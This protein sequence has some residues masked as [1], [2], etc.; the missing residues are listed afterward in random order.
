MNQE[1]TFNHFK[2]VQHQYIRIWT[3]VC[4]GSG[5]SHS[6]LSVK[7]PYTKPSFSGLEL[8]M[9]RAL[10]I[11]FDVHWMQNTDYNANN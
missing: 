8:E 3:W 6:V 11:L 10:G 5:G 9:V 7:L 2:V 4:K 1:L